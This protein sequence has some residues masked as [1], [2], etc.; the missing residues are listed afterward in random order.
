VILVYIISYG[1]QVMV[2][3]KGS[4]TMSISQRGVVFVYHKACTLFL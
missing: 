1:G 3:R 2:M 4:A